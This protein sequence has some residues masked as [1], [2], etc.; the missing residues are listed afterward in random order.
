MEM[1]KKQRLGAGRVAFLARKEGIK[2]KIEAGYTMI[3]VYEEHQKELGISYGQFVNY[4]NKFIRNKLDGNQGNNPAAGATSV[5][6]GDKKPIKK[7]EP[8][9][10]KFKRTENRDDLFKPKPKE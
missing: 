6:A 4:V 3:A 1:E 9:Q 7:Q 10:Q 2:T 5:K 8:G